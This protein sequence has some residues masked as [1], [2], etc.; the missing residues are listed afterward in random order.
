M[1]FAILAQSPREMALTDRIL[2]RYFLSRVRVSIRHRIFVYA[3]KTQTSYPL[4]DLPG[5][6]LQRHRPSERRNLKG[7]SYLHARW[8]LTSAAAMD[9]F[10]GAPKPPQSKKKLSA[11]QRSSQARQ[12]MRSIREEA[13]APGAN[14]ALTLQVLSYWAKIV[15]DN[16]SIDW[17]NGERVGQLGDPGKLKLM[18]RHGRFPGH[19]GSYSDNVIYHDVL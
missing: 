10:V 6:M 16:R 4:T 19:A 3:Q 7:S 14:T 8:R 18:S 13:T 12:R 15:S 5:R 11:L 17:A 2:P 1:Q 9:D